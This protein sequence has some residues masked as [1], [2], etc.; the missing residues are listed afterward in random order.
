LFFVQLLGQG[1][2]TFLASRALSG[3]FYLTP[4]FEPATSGSFFELPHAPQGA[5]LQDEIFLQE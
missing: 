2:S 3:C 1:G 5:I 4:P